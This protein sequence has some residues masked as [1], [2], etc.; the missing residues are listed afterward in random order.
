M[1]IHRRIYEQKFGLIP[2]GCH[3]HHKDGNHNNNSPDNLVCVTAQEHF[4]IHLEQGDYG[5]CWA[6]MR[7]GHIKIDPKT[8][9]EISRRQMKYQWDH[10]R[11]KMLAGR[12]KRDSNDLIGRKWKLRPEIA[13]KVT[14]HLVPFNSDTA[15]VC[16]GTIW[17]N[18]GRVN[19]RISG[20]IPEGW[21]RGRLFTPHN[22]KIKE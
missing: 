13:E 8:K 14:K 1:S 9:S 19:K 2:D 10:H 17:I 22:K 18:D 16:Q 15:R 3:I 21:T 11:D 20:E 12:R 4:D 6:M 7:C 5:A